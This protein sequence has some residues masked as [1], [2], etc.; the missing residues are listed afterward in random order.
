MSKA[1]DCLFG[2]AVVLCIGSW[3]VRFVGESIITTMARLS[4]AWTHARA[5]AEA[6]H[7]EEH[8]V[9]TESEEL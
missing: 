8:D 7:A 9:S 4:V 2:I 6:E 5:D 3:L 1:L